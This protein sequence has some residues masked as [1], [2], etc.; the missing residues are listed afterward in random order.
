MKNRKDGM[1]YMPEAKAEAVVA[2][3]SF[4]IAAI[5]LD[6]GHIFAMV[7]GLVN[8]G[9]TLKWVYDPDQKKIDTFREKFPQ[10][11][12]AE[13]EAAVLA[14][15]TVVL[16]AAAC[17]TSERAALGI[18]VMQSGKDYFVDKAP[19][20]TL[21]Q[22]DDVRKVCAQTGRKYAVSFSERISSEAAVFAGQ[23][24]K[25]GKIGKVLQVLGMGPHRLGAANR[26]AWFFEKEKY[27]GI[28]CDIGSHQIEQ[29]LFFTGATDATVVNS[30]V[31]NYNHPEY[32]EL[33]D[34]GEANLVGTN[35]ASGYFRVDW[36]N[37]DGLCT[38]GDGR[39]FI[40]GTEGYI[41]MR[42]Y[43]NVGV[44]ER[45][46]HVFWVDA[47]GEH[48]ECVEGKMGYPFFGEF[49][50]DCVNRTELAM[51]QEHALKAAEL[52]IQAEMLARK[53]H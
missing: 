20:T 26:P 32:P 44:D 51:T 27:G 7:A 12:Q 18:R 38:W 30:N 48:Y 37:P 17:V 5:G 3:G 35:G 50:L 47:E 49:I 24:V 14:D 1:N 52:C 6:H 10:A 33:E 16:V 36:F 53:L 42:K 31:A 8:A 11:Q 25:E 13:S 22:I 28:L 4:V 29:F 19:M 9:A 46:S 43:V 39:T 21:A 41:E 40:L 45:E 15:E 34:F 23:L 2:P